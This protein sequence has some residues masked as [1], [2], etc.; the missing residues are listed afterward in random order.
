MD[1]LLQEVEFIEKKLNIKFPVDTFREKLYGRAVKL[2]EEV[3]ELCSEV[4]S[5]TKDQRIEKLNK[6]S[7]E[8]LE[9]EI[10]DVII[11]VLVIAKTMDV[12]VQEA[13]KNKIEKI[14]NRLL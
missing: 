11:S 8:S 2:N 7:K 14:K 6:S 5:F 1:K 3:G 9:E 10:A 13:L 4:L 12:D